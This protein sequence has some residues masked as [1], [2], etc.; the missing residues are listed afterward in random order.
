M[1]E[2]P[3]GAKLIFPEEEAEIVDLKAYLHELNIAKEAEKC[4]TEMDH[5]KEDIDND[6]KQ[7]EEEEEAI[8]EEEEYIK[9]DVIRKFQYD[10]NTTTCMTNKFPETD[11]ESALSFAPGEGKIPTS[12]LRD[13]NWDINSFPNLHPSGKNKMFQ[14]RDVRL[15]PQE[16]LVQRM[17]NNDQR[18]E[19]CTPYVFAAV[20][21][22][23]E[24]QM[25]RNIGLSF[26]KGKLSESSGGSRSYKLDD[27]H[28]VLDDVR[29]TPRYWKKAKMEM[30][31]K[32]DNFGPFHWFY[33]LSCADMRWEENFS[34][35]LKSK[36]YKI[37]WKQEESK[38]DSHSQNV[39]VEV[40]F[41]KNGKTE[42]VPLK[43]FLENE[44]EESLHESI[45]TNVFVA[46]RNFMQ[47]VKAFRT[48]IMMGKNSPMRIMYWSDKME[49][50]GRG[51]G[52]I[53]GV[54]WSDLQAVSKL[55]EDE[56]KMNII[57]SNNKK[58]MIYYEDDK[59][60]SNLEDAYRNLR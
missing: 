37:I 25:E 34:T 14:E 47:R 49:F 33:T 19:Q 31:A 55:I 8:K 13:E 12:I 42:Q 39:V 54:A 36:G 20:G 29:G 7:V 4:S 26:S 51:A 50:Q 24:K 52:H 15:N 56:R 41:Q 44:C 2:D 60:R 59:E 5:A 17:R 16:Y 23:E 9:N 43:Y 6:L 30:L 46:T 10:Y 1:E 45:R 21:Y 53:H 35:I 32:I 18:F 11:A 3:I 27:A 28:S 38:E 40:E 58:E 48:E 57:I 22:L